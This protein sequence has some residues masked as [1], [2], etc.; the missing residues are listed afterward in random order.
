MQVFLG[1]EGVTSTILRPTGMA[2]FDGVKLNVLS[3]GDFINPGVK[4]KIVRVDG[5]R[6]VV[7][8]V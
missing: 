4:V 3:D 1:K 7:K 6:V 2:E 8:P 5:S